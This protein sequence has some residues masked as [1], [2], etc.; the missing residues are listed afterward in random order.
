MLFAIARFEFRYLLRNPLVWLTAAV[1]FA[2]F[3]VG[4]SSGLELGSEGGL[5]GNSAFATL[6]NYMMVSIF[7]M[8][9]TTAFVA[10][11]VIRDDETG[12][13]PIIRSTSITKFEYLIGRFAGAFAVAALC[14]L[15]VP[16]AIWLAPLVPWTDPATV[17]PNRLVDHLY[18]Y[19]LF[20]LP[21][22][23]IHS[24]VF[25]AL[26]TVT[27]SMMATYLGIVGFA[28]GFFVLDNLFGDRPQLQMVV[29]LADP[30]GA[31]AVK[32]ITRYWTVPQRN[33]TLPDFTGVLLYN[34]LIWISIALLC[35]ALAYGAYH[36]ADQ[37]M[38]KRERKKQK[39]AERADEAANASRTVDSVSLPVPE[40][41]RAWLRAM[42][43]MRTRF[44]IKQV[45]L[46]PAFVIL[47]AWMLL[48]TLITLLT[49]RD[50][51]GR[52]TYP[53][54]LSMIPEL[55]NGLGVIP[56]IVAIFYAGELV[57]RER[58]RRIHELIDASP[59]PN[60]THV[61]SKTAAM[62]LVLMAILLTTVVASVVVQLSLGY[63][64]LEIG[65]YLLWYVLPSTWDLVLLAALAVFVQAVSPSKAVGWGVM[66]LFLACQQLNP[67]I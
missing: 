1:T 38:S 63:T 9:V 31:R 48:T 19:F 11:A 8:F 16:V 62:A 36:F 65:K 67:T 61:V 21:N 55:E 58:S 41:G 50:P 32:D 22:I 42:L 30:F 59:M 60:W 12:F 26:A 24:A 44:E 51:D 40:H 54:T 27:R 35:L 10:N 23:L 46:S 45:S 33:V 49:Q 2:A 15:V 64:D 66:V 25:F 47:M 4:I 43:W 20:G 28:S 14:L 34:R 53:T 37:G 39:L 5:L 18:S 29:A 3:F 57:W 7:F 56:L 6:R 17:G 52:P 13:G